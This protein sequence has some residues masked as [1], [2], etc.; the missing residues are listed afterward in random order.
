VPSVTLFQQLAPREVRARVMSARSALLSVA[1]AVSYGAA[2][3]LT[4]RLAPHVVM[5]VAGALLAAVTVGA[6][7]VSAE[8]R[9]R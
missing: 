9:T 1:I 2:T 4:A 8:L 3:L 7:L 5:G 6:A